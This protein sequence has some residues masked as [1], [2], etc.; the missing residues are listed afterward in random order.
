MENYTLKEN[1]VILYRGSAVLLPDGKSSGKNATMNDLLLTNFNIVLTIK[2]KKLLKTIEETLTYSIS[3]IKI[4]DEKIQVIRKR[5]IVDIYLKTAELFLD[6]KKEK[7]AKL[8]CNNALKEISGES[9]FVRSVKKTRKAIKETNEALDIDV[10]EIAKTTT[11]TACE[12]AANLGS[13]KGV[14]KGTRILSSVASTL[15][16]NSKKK[17]K[18]L[19]KTS[20]NETEKRKNNSEETSF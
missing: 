11:V 14:G 3:D 12:V 7:E 10:L 15:L 18:E 17:E 13:V 19:L 2:K 1:E 5:N 8:F 6:F 4:H 20:E 16:G 9:K